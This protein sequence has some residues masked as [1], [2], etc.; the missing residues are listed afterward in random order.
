MMNLNDWW[1]TMG[2]G[3][4][5]FYAIAF[6]STLCLILQTGLMLFGLDHGIDFETEAAADF[7]HDDGGLHLLSVRTIISFLVGFGWVGVITLK[8]GAGMLIA[9]FLATIAGF[10]LMMT[11]FWIMR[12]FARLQSDGTLNF[13]NAIGEIGTVYLPIPAEKES[14]GQI[15]VMIQGRLMVVRAFTSNQDKLEN[16]SKVRVIDVVGEDALLV[17]PM[18]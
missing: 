10:G 12:S 4:Q 16:R 9:L 1:D 11:V 15:E 18:D 2:T 8:S 5:V 14:A 7:D 3:I 13:A 17:Q 6:L